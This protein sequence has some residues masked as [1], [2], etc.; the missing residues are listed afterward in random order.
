M[1][2][3]PLATVFLI[4]LL[5]G[6]APRAICAREQFIFRSTIR[7]QNRGE[8]AYI[9]TREDSTLHIFPDTTWQTVSFRNASHGIREE[10]T[11]I[12]GNRV[13]V[14]DLPSSIPPGE[15][16]VFSIEYI[17]ASEDRPREEINTAEAWEITDIPLELVERY[18][19]ETETFRRNEE[20]EALAREL[21]E[22][23]S[24]VLGVVTSILGWIVSNVTY[25]SF[26]VPLY[27]DETLEDL[28]GDCDD[29]AILF[30]SM[31]R[32]VD[33]PA[34]LQIGVVFSESISSEKDTL[35]GHLTY[36]QEGVGWHGWAMVYIPPWGWVPVDL[37]LTSSR[38]PLEMILQAPEYES[39]IVPAFNVSRQAYIGE[40]RV[41]RELL[42]VSDLYI[43]VSDIVLE[44]SM[45]P[46]FTNILY[47]GIGLAAG[48]VIV[49]SIMFV[50]RRRAIMWD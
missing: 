42:L 32:S 34:I 33:I 14:I 10:Y 29:Q 23:E 2:S 22:G 18:N 38:D 44:D 47:I 13:G 17:I 9:I 16:L 36:R 4:L 25:C 49:F 12:D 8:E 19:S 3:K 28:Q 24:T 45:A 21:A 43:T 41:S 7:L 5:T 46:G 30:I 6:A 20:I 40:S 31:L 27:P 1:R 50:R 11:D 26:E 39:F 37:T 48:T 35:Q 15:T